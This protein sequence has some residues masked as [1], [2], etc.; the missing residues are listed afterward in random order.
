MEESSWLVGRVAGEAVTRLLFAIT[1]R[2][3][4][5][6]FALRATADTSL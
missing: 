5:Y 6:A 3:A 1:R 4:P 2:I